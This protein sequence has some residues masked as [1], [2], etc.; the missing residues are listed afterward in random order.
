[1]RLETIDLREVVKVVNV[2]A[3][4]S[5]DS[6][7]QEGHRAPFD[8]LEE[9]PLWRIIV[10]VQDSSLIGNGSHVSVAVG[11]FGHHAISDGLSC[12]AFHLTFL[13]AL[14]NL[15]SRPPHQFSNMGEA[16]IVP[17]QLPLLPNLELK[18]TLSVS[19][20]FVIIQVFK[21]F[22]YNPVDQLNWSGP[23]I[24][25]DTP[26]P[27]ICNTRSFSLPALAVGKL[28]AKCREQ[29]TTITALVTIIIARKLAVMYPEYKRFT[30][31][32]PF[33]LRKFTGHSPRDMGCYV[34][35]VE[36]YFSSEARPPRGYI[37]CASSPDEKT[38]SSDREKMWDG[39]RAC[40]KFVDINTST[41]HNQNVNLLKFVSDLPKYFLGLL[42]SKRAQA[43]EVTN[44]GVVDGGAGKGDDSKA[45]FD[46]VMFSSGQCTFG[47]PYNVHLATAKNGFMT[48]ALSWETGI[49]GDEEAKDLFSCLEDELMG[50]VE[51]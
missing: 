36:P 12:G 7:V 11:F 32:V 18:A 24:S 33:S 21:A 39:A 9:L 14:N 47:N 29:K 43:F 6:W 23:R 4:A 5:S 40:K 13:D 19:I 31:T 37:S 26:R 46:K 48:A 51:A 28:V 30:G 42:G 2:D 10:A 49:V 25:A 27:P 20:L 41:T 3:N 22:V 17:P 50:L 35:N 8:R 34:S 44:L 15:T 38:S 45:S 16:V 1:M